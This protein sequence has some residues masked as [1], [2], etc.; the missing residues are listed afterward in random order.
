V[1]LDN[2]SLGCDP[3]RDTAK[4]GDD[5]RAKTERISQTLRF[6]LSRVAALK[7]LV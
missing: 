6:E 2:G 7:K 3:H 5:L 4:D 1:A